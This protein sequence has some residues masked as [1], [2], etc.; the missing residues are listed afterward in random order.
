MNNVKRGAGRKYRGAR[1]KDRA[2]G[3]RDV[4]SRRKEED[5]V[6]RQRSC[7]G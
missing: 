7:R 3:G 5:Q 6:E 2:A 1:G 4:E